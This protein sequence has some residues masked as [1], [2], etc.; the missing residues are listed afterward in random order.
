MQL[1]DECNLKNHIM[2]V[3]LSIISNVSQKANYDGQTEKATYRGS[4][5][6]CNLKKAMCNLQIANCKIKSLKC[7]VINVTLKYDTKF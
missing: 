6:N 5:Q 1:E 7:N 3:W 2:D 4:A